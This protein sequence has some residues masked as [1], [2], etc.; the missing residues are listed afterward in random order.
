MMSQSPSSAAQATLAHQIA[1]AMRKRDPSLL[2]KLFA[3]ATPQTMLA[4]AEAAMRERRWNDAAELFDRVAPRDAAASLKRCLS[5]NLAALSIHRPGVY[6]ILV[7]LPKSDH[8]GLGTSASGHPTIVCR[9]SDG[10]NISLSPGNQPLANLAQ[11]M[12]QLQPV[13]ASGQSIGL[14]GMGDGYLFHQLAHKPPALFMDQQQPVFLLE[15][16]AHVVLTALMIHDYTGPMGPIE[17]RRIHWFVGS[18]WA[19]DLRETFKG[20]LA[21]PA[22]NVSLMMSLTPEPIQATLSAILREIAQREKQLEAAVA[23]YYAGRTPQASAELFGAHP[24][25]QPR[26]LLLTTRFSTVLQYATRDAAAAFEQ[27]GWEAHVLIEATPGHRV[28]TTA[29]RDAVATF[30]PDLVF[31]IDHQRQEHGTLFPPELPFA[32]WFQD[33]LP[34]LMTPTAGDAI[35]PTDFVLTDAPFTYVQTARYPRR[36]MIALSKL[37]APPPLLPRPTSRG[38][39]IVFISNASG[40][41]AQLLQSAPAGLLGTGDAE[42]RLVQTCAQ[43]LVLLHEQGQ[44]LPTYLDIL[45]F[46]RDLLAEHG[47]NP[48]ADQCHALTRWLTHPLADA[49]Y[50]QQTLRWAIAAAK[51]LG[52][53]LG[54]HGKGWETHPEFAPHARG[55]VAPGRALHELTRRSAINL[56]IA[57]YFCLHQRLLDGICSGAFFLVREHVSDTAPAALLNLLHA[58]CPPGVSD[59]PAARQAIPLTLRDEFE[60]LVIDSQRALCPTETEDPIEAIRVWEEAQL[61]APGER[62]LPH[63]DEVSFSDA[64]QMKARIERFVHA[65]EARE[66]MVLAQRE[67][68]LKRLTYLAGVRRITRTMSERLMEQSAQISA[69]RHGKIDL[70]RAA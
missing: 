31:Q 43:R 68:I 37:T 13:M 57:P 3:Q 5:R 47:L 33:H 8:C 11:A 23:G 56:Q 27:A 44:T 12:T 70:E 16:D 67:N 66:T 42:R 7:S 62:P 58:H 64:A 2:Q 14:C 21:L 39:D 28:L 54:L 4:L 61:L 6:E 15:P 9:R 17:Q 36:Q 50:R 63:L 48:P 41:A 19:A 51:D 22:P 69:G 24:P 30:R 52:L 1:S 49:L 46:V 26:A 38:D 18:E 35:G 53:T 32:A 40:Q 60:R 25:R 55:S 29:I 45:R 59:L 65:P 10:Q 20:D 34:H